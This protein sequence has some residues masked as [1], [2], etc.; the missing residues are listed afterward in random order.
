MDSK[1]REQL[2]AA[3]PVGTEILPTRL[4]LADGRHVVSVAIDGKREDIDPRLAERGLDQGDSPALF[5]ERTLGQYC[6]YSDLA[7]SKNMFLKSRERR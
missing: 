5:Y 6:I 7:V 4:D 3:L 1:G 2:V